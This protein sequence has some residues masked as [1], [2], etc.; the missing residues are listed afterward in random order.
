MCSVLGSHFRGL[1][2]TVMCAAHSQASDWIL[3]QYEGVSILKMKKQLCRV[4][5]F[6]AVIELVGD[7]IRFEIR[8]TASQSIPAPNLVLFLHQLGTL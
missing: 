7:G 3:R 6:P 5:S 2:D 1:P 4:S 8:C